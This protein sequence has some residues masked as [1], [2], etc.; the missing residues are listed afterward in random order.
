MTQAQ[1]Y[2]KKFSSVIAECMKI[3]PWFDYKGLTIKKE[4]GG[5]GVRGTLFDT[6]Q[7][8]KNYIDKVAA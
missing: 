5:W 3:T 1:R 6:K 7:D 8:A 2:N 4:Y